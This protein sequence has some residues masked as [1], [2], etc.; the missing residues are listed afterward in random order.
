MKVHNIT[1]DTINGKQHTFTPMEHSTTYLMDQACISLLTIVVMLVKHRSRF[2][3]S[4]QLNITLHR[5]ILCIAICTSLLNLRIST[6]G[7]LIRTLFVELSRVLNH[8]LDYDG[9][10]FYQ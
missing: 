4:V 1:T 6:T 5:I 10:R 8:L 9:E 7:A 2:Y 3:P